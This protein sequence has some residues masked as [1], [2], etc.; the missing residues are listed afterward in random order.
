MAIQWDNSYSVGIKTFDQHHQ[1]ILELLNTLEVSGNA[2]KSDGEAVIKALKE[3]LDYSKYHFSAEESELAEHNYPNL[4][5]QKNEHKRFTTKIEDFT[6]LFLA[7]SEPK[8]SEVTDFL[9]D[10]ILNHIHEVD[11]NYGA[12]LHDK[13]CR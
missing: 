5:Q 2:A 1:K 12:F 8:V 4:Q 7:G 13:G 6:T 11:K 10:W 3:L 9:R